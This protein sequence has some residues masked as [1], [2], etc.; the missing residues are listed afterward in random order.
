MDDKFAGIGDAFLEKVG[1]SLDQVASKDFDRTEPERQLFYPTSVFHV[2][3]GAFVVQEGLWS[4]DSQ[5]STVTQS[6]KRA[7]FDAIEPGGSVEFRLQ[8]M[9]PREWDKIA[10]SKGMD[11]RVAESCRSSQ[12]CLG[13]RSRTVRD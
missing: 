7:C 9:D 5:V 1:R 4:K 6:A 10:S 8:V 13:I 3:Q 12:V 2:V 11:E